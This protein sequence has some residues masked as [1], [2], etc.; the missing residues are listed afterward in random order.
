[1]RTLCAACC[2]NDWFATTTLAQSNTQVLRSADTTVP[3]LQSC[4]TRNARK[5]HAHH[6]TRDM[7]HAALPHAASRPPTCHRPHA[8][9]LIEPRRFLRV[10]V[11]GCVGVDV[12]PG[13][14]EG[15]RHNLAGRCT[16]EVRIR[17][18]RAR[19]ALVRADRRRI[20]ARCARRALRRLAG[21]H[22]ARRT[23]RALSGAATPLQCSK[24]CRP[25][26]NCAMIRAA[27]KYTRQRATP[28]RDAAG[29]CG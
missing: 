18:R 24:A 4:T 19:R 9:R 1:M 13:G 7:R 14:G 20:R 26:S 10:C 6:G 3:S 21:A 5:R 2:L 25:W 16:G 17:A 29:G 27:F 8:A 22:R 11:R 15:M 23:R 28:G 12:F